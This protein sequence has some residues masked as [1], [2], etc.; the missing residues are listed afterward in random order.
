MKYAIVIFAAVVLLYVNH[1]KGGALLK[2]CLFRKSGFENLQKTISAF[3]YTYSLKQHVMICIMML[4]VIGY[5][6]SL[7]E[8]NV[9]TM[10]FLFVL[11]A[12]LLPSII[13]WIMYNSYQEKQ[14]NDT[15]LFLQHFLAM[16]KLNPKTYQVLGDCR[17]VVG[18][19]LREVLDQMIIKL[20]LG[21]T[22]HEAFEIMFER[23]P[24]FIIHNL[25]TLVETIEMHGTTE[26]M[27]GLEL[28]QDDIDDWIEDVYLFKKQQIQAKNR[29]LMLCGLS[30]I[31]AVFA[32]N[33]LKQISFETGGIVYQTSILIF[34]ATI[35][36]TLMMAHK[37]LGESWIDKEEL[38]C[39]RK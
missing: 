32:K 14:F 20:E 3:G 7:F 27:E 9:D 12:S 29:M 18:D 5:A 1:R 24:H 19:E 35:I 33:M 11:A 17:E 8:V 39:L 36:I 31:I 38:I 6:C 15:T 16:F 37:V 21:G 30:C 4:S 10:M 26:Y 22:L 23:N 2:H 25:A 34:F 13:I 28:I